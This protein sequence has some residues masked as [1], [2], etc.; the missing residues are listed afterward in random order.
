M[1]S[2]NAFGRRKSTCL[3]RYWLIVTWSWWHFLNVGDGISILKTSFESSARSKCKKLVDADDQNDQNRHQHLEVVTNTFGSM[4]VDSRLRRLHP[5]FLQ[6][7]GEW[8]FFSW[9]YHTWTYSDDEPWYYSEGVRWTRW[10]VHLMNVARSWRPDVN[11]GL[12][13]I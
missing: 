8:I 9:T 10:T 3:S 12:L 7:D 13:I 4:D 5:S 2:V 6:V 1:P 11:V